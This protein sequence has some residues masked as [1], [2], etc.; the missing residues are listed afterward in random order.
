V[1]EDKIIV[2]DTKDAER[3]TFDFIAGENIP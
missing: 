3:F 1:I 2:L